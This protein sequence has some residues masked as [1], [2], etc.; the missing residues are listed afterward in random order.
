MAKVKTSFFCQN[1]GAQ[2]A[3]WMGQCTT[4][5]EWNTI[6]EELIQKEEKRSWKQDTSDRKTNKAL[7]ISAIE[8]NKE[9]RIHTQQQRTKHSSW[10]WLGPWLS[11]FTG[12]RTRYWKVNLIAS[13][14]T[15]NETQSL[16]C[17][18]RRKPIPNKN[19]S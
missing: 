2:H 19:A 15:R 13:G 16:I 3:K 18:W 5:N 12:W 10:W 1:C 9:I 8:I 4:C 14:C 11:Y 17:F 6:V 7:A